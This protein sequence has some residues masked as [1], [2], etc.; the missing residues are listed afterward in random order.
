MIYYEIKL[1]KTFRISFSKVIRKNN[2]IIVE[3]LLFEKKNNIIFF[4]RTENTTKY[5]DVKM[6]TLAPDNAAEGKG[7]K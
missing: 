3:Y 5:S 6:D 1:S 4:I 2:N 7:G